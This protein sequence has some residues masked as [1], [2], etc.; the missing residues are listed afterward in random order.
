MWCWILG[1]T[2]TC[3]VIALALSKLLSIVLLQISY[4]RLDRCSEH[5]W[6]EPE[7][8]TVVGNGVKIICLMMFT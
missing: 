6:G 2:C 7:R 4:T 5:R 8:D 3:V 1:G